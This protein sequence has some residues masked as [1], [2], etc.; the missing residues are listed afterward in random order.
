MEYKAQVSDQKKNLVKELA[1]LM[2]LYPVVGI[3]DVEGLPAPQFQTMRAKLHDSV[4]IKMSK[5]RLISLAI[6]MVK[7]KKGLEGL[8]D[9]LRGMPAIIFT[10]ENP[11]KLFKVL[12]QNK[13]KAPAKPGQIAPNDIVVKA[14]PTPFAPGP[15]IGQLGQYKIKAGIEAGKIIIKENAI[16]VREGQV[17]NEELAG[18]LTR[19]GITPME[20]GL[21][22]TG[23]YEEGS[24][25][26]KKILA[27]DEQEYIDN[28]SNCARWA[29]NLAVFSAYASKDTAEAL[30]QKAFREARNLSVNEAIPASDIIDMLLAKA[31]ME[32]LAVKAQAGV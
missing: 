6:G 3:V 15:I 28:M 25:F 20:I 29:L 7:N 24:I 16:P 26:D 9:R 17:I 23:V 22:L 13:S 32:M 2:E 14:G 4:I 11:F 30:L 21:N 31:N 5:K 12:E 19:L 10:K 18:L 1:D 8:K 27:I